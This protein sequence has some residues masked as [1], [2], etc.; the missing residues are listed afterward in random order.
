MKISIPFTDKTLLIGKKEVQ[1]AKQSLM[2]AYW[3]NTF[4]NI[5]SSAARIGFD[6]LYQIY[7]NV[8]DVKMAVRRKQNA[9]AKEGFRF[10][11]A[12]NVNEV[13]TSES[14]IRVSQLLDNARMPFNVFVGITIRDLDVAGNAYWQIVKSKTGE[15]MGLKIVDPRTMIVVADKFGNVLHYKQRVG[16]NEDI[17]FEKDEIIHIVLDY[18]TY[19]PLLGASPIEAIVWDAKSELAAGMSNWVFYENNAVP[20]HL[21]IV[22]EELSPDQ[23]QE[24]KRNMDQQYKGAKNRFKTGIIPFVKDI[25][26]I[27]PSQKEMQYIQSRQFN[28]SKVVVAFGVDKFL[29]GYTEKVQR[30]NADV[31]KA[32]FYEDTIRPLEILLE[33]VVNNK[34]LP[35]LGF[36]DF[37]FKVNPSNYDNEDVVYKRTR[38]DVQA[39]IMTINEAREARG[40]DPSENELADELLHNGNLIDDL[41]AEALAPVTAALK[42]QV[43]RKENLLTNLLD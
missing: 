1:A 38:D 15:V 30:G 14:T 12:N 31:I 8:V 41:A 37:L 20:S 4:S 43:E 17:Q 39:G 23:W 25:K 28:T 22:E 24:L 5:K 32:M 34:L 9:T 16:G 13:V 3:Q 19:N 10:V 18:S 33:Q 36:T 35:L 11:D 26:T 40:L 6:T 27:T 29:L 42:D 21:M 2:H 7:N